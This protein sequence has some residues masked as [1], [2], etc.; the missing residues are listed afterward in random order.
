MKLPLPPRPG[1]NAQAWT[2]TECFVSMT[3]LS[4]MAL[5]VCSAMSSGYLLIKSV[6]EDLRATEILAQKM[7]AV[8]L[9]TWSQLSNCPNS[10]REYYSPAG[11]TNN[12][13]GVLY[14]GTISVGGATNVPDTVSYK[15]SIRLV[16]VSLR[17]TNDNCA[18]G[19]VHTREMQTQAARSGMQNYIWGVRP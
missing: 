17:W 11:F 14:S 12:T 2:I 5:T 16:T 8:R 9:L 7:E 13:Q 10:F 18:N 1:T 19:L 3:L 4:G 6:R 15:D